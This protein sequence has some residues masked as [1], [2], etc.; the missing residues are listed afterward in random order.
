MSFSPE[1]WPGVGFALE[2]DV[3]E[4]LISLDG[5]SQE[6]IDEEIN[7]AMQ[8]WI[9]LTPV[10]LVFTA[11]TSWPTKCSHLFAC[12]ASGEIIVPFLIPTTFAILVIY[13][14][15]ATLLVR[16]L[17]THISQKTLPAIPMIILVLAWVASTT[18]GN[19]LTH[20]FHAQPIQAFNEMIKEIGESTTNS[21]F[22]PGSTI[23]QRSMGSREEGYSPQ[24][25]IVWFE[26]ER[27]KL[28]TSIY[29]H[30]PFLPKNTC[31]REESPLAV[32]TENVWSC[33]GGDGRTL[34]YTYLSSGGDIL[35][36]VSTPAAFLTKA[37][38]GENTEEIT[39]E[40]LNETLR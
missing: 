32:H 36:K 4:E 28:E 25:L 39:L 40:Y 12:I 37:V 17:L 3:R 38:H 26:R 29:Y 16:S 27:Q 19:F 14:S 8:P 31:G 6:T 30:D 35:V 13:F 22:P 11:A 23:Y 20:R 21:L 9:T 34:Y 1:H 18:A 24:R 2:D 10:S 15:L 7:A 33:I 5:I